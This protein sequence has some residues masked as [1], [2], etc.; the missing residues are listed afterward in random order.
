VPVNLKVKL[1]EAQ[2]ETGVDRVAQHCGP[3]MRA[4]RAETNEKLCEFDRVAVK[5]PIAAPTGWR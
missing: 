4:G 1:K 3:T 5:S 2:F